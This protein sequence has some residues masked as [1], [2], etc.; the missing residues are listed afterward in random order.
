[1]L[2]DRQ[3]LLVKGIFLFS[4]ALKAAKQLCSHF[5]PYWSGTWPPF[6]LSYFWKYKLKQIY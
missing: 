5:K 6:G 4:G 2:F 1:M 3:K